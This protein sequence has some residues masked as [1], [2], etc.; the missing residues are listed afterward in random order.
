MN[1]S[2][3]RKRL[4]LRIQISGSTA[5]KGRT[6]PMFKQRKSSPLRQASYQAP[7]CPKGRQRENSTASTAPF[8]GAAL[9]RW[10]LQYKHALWLLYYGVIQIW[11]GYLEQVVRPV[12]WV[13][14]PLD[15]FIPF[16][17]VFVIPYVAWF[18]YIAVVMVYFGLRSPTDFTKLSISMFMG[19]TVCMVLYGLFPHGQPLRPSLSGREGIFVDMVR[20][21]YAND[22]N[23][24]CFPSIHVLNSLLVHAS[25]HHSPLFAN[26][27]GIR[28]ASLV[29]AVLI[30]LSTV[31]IKQHS[32]LD[33]IAAL[34]LFGVLH[35]L[36]YRRPVT[37]RVIA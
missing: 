36:V 28:T 1:G 29:L 13:R 37:R 19:M 18:A 34:I 14:S 30:C 23:T 8:T 25:I 2:E 21:I 3:L 12:I 5:E 6:V 9:K 35:T 20:K 31:F 10:L 16:V 22:T 27:P 32:I 24:N 17:P 33:G 7:S 4:T 26:K 11:F 15:R